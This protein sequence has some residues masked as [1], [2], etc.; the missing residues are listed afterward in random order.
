M[1]IHQSD[2]LLPLPT[3]A[4]QIPAS[5]TAYD[6]TSYSLDFPTHDRPI[7]LSLVIPTYKE[8]QNIEKIVSLLS[9]QLDQA[10]PGAYELIVVDDDSAGLRNEDSLLRSFGV[11]RQHEERSWE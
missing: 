8:A 10:M 9:Q 6:P 7:L 4:L 11:G 3:G 1:S 5:N 2:A